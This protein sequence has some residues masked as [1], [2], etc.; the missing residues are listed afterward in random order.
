MGVEGAEAPGAGVLEEGAE[1]PGAVVEGV[2]AG[3]MRDT[4]LGVYP[5]T[6]LKN[7]VISTKGQ[8]YIGGA[9]L[10]LVHFPAMRLGKGNRPF[11]TSF[12][13][14]K[15]H[16]KNRVFNGVEG[17]DKLPKI[18]GRH[19]IFL[20]WEQPDKHMNQNMASS[21]EDISSKLPVRL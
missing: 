12:H 4:S 9:N 15:L 11:D 21:L 19:L 14:G 13:Q 17:C 3:R 20:L 7:S 8:A 2:G 16:R 10:L 18:V 1:V 6:F 5:F